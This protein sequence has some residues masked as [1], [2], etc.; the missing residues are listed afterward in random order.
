MATAQ[1]SVISAKLPNG[2]EVKIGDVI[3]W[4]EFDN[5]EKPKEISWP[6]Y[7]EV[8]N[9]T[10]NPEHCSCDLLIGTIYKEDDLPGRRFNT[11]NQYANIYNDDPRDKAKVMSQMDMVSELTDF[12]H[13][14]WKLKKEINEILEN[15]REG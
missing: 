3:K 4:Y 6:K 10:I 2:Q 9:I 11:Y 5:D 13:R 1:Q 14:H 15:D 12:A 8:I 7:G